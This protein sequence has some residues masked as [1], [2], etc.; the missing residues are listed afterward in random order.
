MNLQSYSALLNHDRK[1]PD[2]G[3]RECQNAENDALTKHWDAEDGAVITQSILFLK[4][5]NMR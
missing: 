5:S 2:F 3:T 1:W 4:T